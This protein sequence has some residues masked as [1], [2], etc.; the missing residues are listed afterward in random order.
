VLS[1]RRVLVVVPARG[2][3]KGVPLKNIHPLAGTPL[4]AHVGRVVREL[5]FVDRA[6]VSTD[7]PEILAEARK[8]GLEAPFVRPPDLAGDY[9]SDLQVLRHALRAT[10]QVDAQSYDIV[11]M[12]Q[13]TSP[14]RRSSHVVA[15]VR[16]LV[17]EDWDAVWTVSPTDAKYHPLKQLSIGADGSMTYFDPRGATIIARQALTPVYHRNGAAYVFTRECLVDQ[18]TILGKRTAAVIIT[19]PMISI[20]TPDDFRIAEA[21]LTRR[22]AEDAGPAEPDRVT[23]GH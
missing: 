6:V 13:P 18:D 11:I 16:K 14:L 7:H 19:E 15:A 4:I 12:L 10:E 21:Y 17:D 23:A 22:S 9:V 8:S 5:S 20:D 3:S 2:G 1:N